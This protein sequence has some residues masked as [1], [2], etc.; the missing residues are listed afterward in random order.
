MKNAIPSKVS[1]I[2]LT[3][4]SRVKAEDRPQVTSSLD[5]YTILINH[6]DQDTIALFEEFHILLLDG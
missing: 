6:W 5:A 4:K 1:E 2:K 3:Y